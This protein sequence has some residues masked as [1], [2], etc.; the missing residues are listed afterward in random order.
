VTAAPICHVQD[1]WTRR[2]LI[3]AI[4][5]GLDSIHGLKILTVL[6]TEQK[7]NKITAADSNSSKLTHFSTV[8]LVHVP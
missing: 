6:Y 7:T 8:G 1:G 2:I 5:I 4:H 3:F